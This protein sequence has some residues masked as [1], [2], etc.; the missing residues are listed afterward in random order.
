MIF[1]SPLVIGLLTYLLFIKRVG[2]SHAHPFKTAALFIVCYQGTL[3][4]IQGIELYLRGN[5][6]I[7]NL[8]SITTLSVALAQFVVASFIF[9]KVYEGEDSYLAYAVWAGV[10]FAAIFIFIPQLMRILL[11]NF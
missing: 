6:V 7:P 10:G 4:A 8:I 2:A 9:Y 11:A 5:P 3:A 1:A